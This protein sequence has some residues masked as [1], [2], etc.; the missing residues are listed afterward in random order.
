VIDGLQP[1][2]SDISEV[3][4]W[5]RNAG[6]VR[7]WLNSFNLDLI[8]VERQAESSGEWVLGSAFRCANA[9]AGSPVS[10]PPG[11][12]VEIPLLYSDAFN[13][14]EAPQH[15]EADRGGARYPVPGRYR[16]SARYSVERWASIAEI[17]KNIEVVVSTVFE[18]KSR[19]R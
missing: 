7:V 19:G 11:G 8:D 4:M 9:G 18:V 14:H 5:L 12:S 1:S 3:R 13:L 10:L 6:H 16:V 2:Y 15:F 17:P